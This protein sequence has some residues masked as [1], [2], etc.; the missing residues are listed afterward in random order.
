MWKQCDSRW[1][2][3]QLGFGRN[4]ICSAGCLMTSVSMAVT[5]TVGLANPLTVNDWLK[6][7]GGYVGGTGDFIW[8]AV[9]P[10]GLQFGG[11]STEMNSIGAHL[12]FTHFVIA[13]V[14]QGRH[15][16]IVTGVSGNQIIVNDPGYNRDSYPISE[17][18]EYG[19][20]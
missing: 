16:V 11:F 12:Y 2:G 19:W 15:W 5:M 10:L 8:G 4:T 13:N 7:N 6:N 14:N 18:V 9:R 17:I 1:G 3:N 20:Y